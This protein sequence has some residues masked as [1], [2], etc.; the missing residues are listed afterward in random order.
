[1]PSL[2]D[3]LN[4]NPDL[5]RTGEKRG[6]VVT[7]DVNVIE[8]D[9]DS[10]DFIHLGSQFTASKDDIIDIS[11]SSRQVAGLQGK[12]A[13][14]T[15]KPSARLEWKQ[16]VTAS[17]LS[18]TVPLAFALPTVGAPQF[19]ERPGLADWGAKV[20]YPGAMSF[21]STSTASTCDCY[22]NG[23]ADDTKHDDW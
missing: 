5:S 1:M 14:L 20:G 13:L 21:A 4:N 18:A 11:D 8:A 6:D 17:E 15:L 10:V 9:S 19:S 22:S 23:V 7:L 3:F 16:Y 12:P 2:V